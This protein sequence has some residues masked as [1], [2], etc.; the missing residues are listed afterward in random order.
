MQVV[1]ERCA[2]GEKECIAL[3]IPAGRHTGTASGFNKTVTRKDRYIVSG[4]SSARLEE[5][6]QKYWP[7]SSIWLLTIR[8]GRDRQG[9]G[10]CAKRS[11]ERVGSD[12][13]GGSNEG[14]R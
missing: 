12:E 3:S 14:M 4:S 9:H 1:F 8:V 7:G 5:G 13:R 10:G 2:S 6:R 11:G